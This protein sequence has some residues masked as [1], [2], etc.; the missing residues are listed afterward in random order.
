MTVVPAFVAGVG[1]I[2]A[3]TPPRSDG[4]I[5]PLVLY[6]AKRAGATTVVKAG[7]AQ[8]IAA[9]TFGTNSVP[10]V[11]KIVGPG[12][13]FVTEA[14][15]QVSGA[16]G[17]DGLAGATELAIVAGSTADVRWLAADLVAQ[18]EHDPDAI[19]TLVVLDPD[20][21]EA[22][23]KAL[24]AEV[25]KAAR[26][27]VVEVALANARAVIVKDLEQAVDTVNDLAPE[28]LH[29]VIDDPATFVS[30]VRAAG[31]IFVGPFT[32]VPFGDY[33]VASNH[34]L[35]T[36]GTARFA[37]GL[38]S[39]DFVRVTSVVEMTDDAAAR[40]AP[41]VSALARSEGLIGHARAVEIRAEDGGGK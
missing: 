27:D 3:C 2:V 18:A 31:A 29:V 7:G 11:D 25:A 41:E 38:R 36:S 26:R 12:N 22:V 4:S 9:L 20:L 35:P 39:S 10:S 37:N 34:V 6:A 19:A 8:A 5:H 15:R 32:P 17:I 30:A 33:G 14:K 28:H 40:L 13:A 1:Q 24:E 23:E 16:V 21:V